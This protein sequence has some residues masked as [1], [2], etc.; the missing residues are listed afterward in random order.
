[1]LRLPKALYL[2]T[3]SSDLRRMAGSFLNVFRSSASASLRAAMMRSVAE[4]RSPRK[5][6]SPEKCPV[7]IAA[8]GAG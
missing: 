4:R 2:R 7:P 3:S 5:A 6:E 1:M 8:S